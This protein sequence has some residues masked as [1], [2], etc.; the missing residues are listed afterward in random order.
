MYFRLGRL[1]QIRGTLQVASS[2]ARPLPISQLACLSYV[3]LYIQILGKVTCERLSPELVSG[4][5][6]ATNVVFPRSTVGGQGVGSTVGGQGVGSTVGGQGVGSTVG[7][8]GVGSTV[9]AASFTE[10]SG[11][12]S[13]AAETASGTEGIAFDWLENSSTSL[14]KSSTEPVEAAGGWEWSYSASSSSSS[15]EPS[16][17]VM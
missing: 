15:E 12:G 2:K 8:Q 1:L 3:R 13:G 16:E 14:V 11:A 5:G 10:C 4:A 6:L 9:G 7:G 17:P